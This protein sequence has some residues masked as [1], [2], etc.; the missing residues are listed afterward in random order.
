MTQLLKRGLTVHNLN[1]RTRLET[2]FVC[3]KE[4]KTF[5]LSKPW[6]KKNAHSLSTC[7]RLS[8]FT[9]SV[10]SSEASHIQRFLEET[11]CRYSVFVQNAGFLLNVYHAVDTVSQ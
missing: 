4:T 5:V 6:I 1:S 10:S 2:S 9:L 7:G 3:H 8:T 11:D